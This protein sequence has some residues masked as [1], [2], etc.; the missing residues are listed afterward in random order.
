MEMQKAVGILT[1]KVDRLCE[2]VKTH[3][4]RLDGMRL[5]MALIAGGAAALG[6][7]IGALIAVVN[8]VPWERIF[9]AAH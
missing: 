6:G 9:P 7:L 2:D 8:A 5:K 4:E 1:A 3:G